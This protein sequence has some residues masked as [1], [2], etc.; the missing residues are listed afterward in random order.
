MIK[1][2]AVLLLVFSLIFPVSATVIYQKKDSGKTFNTIAGNSFRIELASNPTTGFDWHFEGLDAKSFKIVSSGF[3]PPDAK[4]VGAGGTDFWEI[5]PLKAGRHSIQLLY[6]RIWEGKSKAVDRYTLQLNVLPAEII[7]KKNFGKGMVV[8]GCKSGNF[9]CLAIYKGDKLLYRFSP[10]GPLAESYPRPLML[11]K[12]EICG[13]TIVTSWGETGADYFGTHPIVFKHINGKFRAVS[14][15]SG[16]LADDPQIKP[17]SWTSKDFYVT[18]YYD[19]SEK[20]KTILT[21][22][23]KVNQN[24]E[25]ELSFYGDDLPH[26]AKHKYVIIRLPYAN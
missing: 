7:F 23:I 1:N 18:N 26:A 10:A 3:I 5:K 12:A 19:P 8:V 16:N 2:L 13:T 21:Q 25:I 17:F 6:Y 15:Y 11:E 4:L 24:D 20:V 14:F 9:S 22:G